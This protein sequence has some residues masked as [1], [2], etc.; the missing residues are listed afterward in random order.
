VITRV[1]VNGIEVEFDEQR[2]EL[3]LAGKPSLMMWSESTTAGLMLGMTRMVGER[4]FQLAMQ[5][6]GRESVDE[7]WRY[8]SSFPTFEEGFAALTKV[9]WP[10]GW[11]FWEIVWID[12]KK[13]EACFRARNDWESYYQKALGVVWGSCMLAGK[14]AGMCTRLFGENCWAEQTA[15][16]ARGDAYDEFVVRRSDVTIENELTKFLREGEA[17]GAD[18]PVA[19]EKLEREVAER[20]HVEH[21]L[22]DKLTLIERQKADIMAMSTPIVQIWSGVLMLPVIGSLDAERAAHIM[23][24]LLGMIVRNRSQF[25]I[26]DL[27]G[28]EQVDTETADHLLQIIRSVQLLGARS[29]VTGIRPAVAQTMTSLGVDL[30]GL[31]TLGNLEEGLRTCIRWMSGGR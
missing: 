29:V 22:R 8:I 16:A 28:V 26:V 27:T 5:S 21:E 10:A 2:Y 30:G 19:L 12:R 7:D 20:M 13:K 18:L 14:F 17:T 9:A 25:A 3:R 6:G 31:T 1:E 4:R 11:G 23:D 15:H 24:K